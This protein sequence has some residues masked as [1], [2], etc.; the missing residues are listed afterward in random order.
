MW[1]KKFILEKLTWEKNHS[2]V[3][4][5]GQVLLKEGHFSCLIFSRFII[6]TFRNYFIKSSSTWLSQHQPTSAAN[7][8]YILQLMMTFSYGETDVWTSACLPNRRIVHCAADDDFVKLLYYLHNC[9]MH[10]KKVIFF[11]HPNFMKKVILSCLKMNLKIYHN[12][13]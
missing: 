9:I 3:E 6:F 5:Q 8:C 7:V 10:L 4:V 13:R 1:G 11:W 2:H 12:L